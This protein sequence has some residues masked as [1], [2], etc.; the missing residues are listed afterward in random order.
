LS[1][2]DSLQVKYLEPGVNYEK[3]Y[4]PR[5][6]KLILLN[7]KKL[8]VAKF[9]IQMNKNWRIGRIPEKWLTLIPI[10]DSFRNNCSTNP[11]NYYETQFSKTFDNWKTSLYIAIKSH[12]VSLFHVI[13]SSLW[14]CTNLAPTLQTVAFHRKRR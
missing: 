1:K 14:Q 6:T 11:I 9:N 3:G 10:K 7:C 8:C 2:L 5:K 12:H 4:Y 13:D